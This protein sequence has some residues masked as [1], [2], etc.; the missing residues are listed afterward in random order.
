MSVSD[1]TEQG[2]HATFLRLAR[3]WKAA[4]KALVAFQHTVFEG[5]ALRPPATSDELDEL[6]RLWA[7]ERKAREA[8]DLYLTNDFE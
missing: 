8:L 2:T 5:G 1:C 6:D 4:F 7:E 3:E